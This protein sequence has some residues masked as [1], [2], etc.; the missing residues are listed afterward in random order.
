MNAPQ[1][2]TRARVAIIGAGI[3][4]ATCAQILQAAGHAV[5]VVDKSRGAGGRMATKRL[6]WTDAQGATRQARFDHG[7]PGFA[8]EDPASAN[9]L[10]DRQMSHQKAAWMLRSHL[11]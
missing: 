2:P 1:P 7:A 8:A 10:A 3:A 4:G 9:L 11:S 5:H 6:Q